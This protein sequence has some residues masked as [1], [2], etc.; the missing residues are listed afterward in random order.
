MSDELHIICDGTYMRCH[1]DIISLEAY[2][3]FISGE[4]PNI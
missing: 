3:V 1:V 4:I 2:Y